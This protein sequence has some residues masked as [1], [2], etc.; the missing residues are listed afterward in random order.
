MRSG[1][2]IRLLC[3]LTVAFVLGAGG[4]AFGQDTDA[5]FRDGM[6]A[7]E[8]AVRLP[9][10]GDR[11]A[12]LSEAVAAFHGIL[13]ERPALGRVRLELARAFFLMG[14][15]ELAR[16]HF[17]IVLAGAIPDLV[18]ANV[19]RFLAT[20]R[21]R[22]R[23]H[24]RFGLGIAPD[25]NI[26]ASSG[27]RSVMID[28]PVGPLPFTLNDPAVKESGVGL[29]VRTGG[30]YQHP[31]GPRWR[32]RAGGNLSRREYRGRNFDHMT[33][34]GHA[35]LRW[36]IDMRTEA[37]LLLDARRR[38]SGGTW[39]NREVGPRL[40]MRRRL[41]RH[42]TAHGG[43][44]WHE[45]RHD[46]ATH[47]DGPVTGLYGG[48][49]W[50]AAPTVRLDL[51]GGLGRE[52]TK[53]R[54]DRNDSRWASAGASWALG[55]GFTVSGALT[56]RRTDYEGGR[57]PFLPVAAKRADETITWRLSAHNRGLTFWGFS[58]RVSLVRE[59]R[60]S[61]AQLHG[62]ERTSG[63]LEFIRLF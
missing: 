54:R 37:S 48:V 30:E 49:S 58:P 39:Q 47:L 29:S 6:A 33:L 59:N 38:Q 28:T 36:L 8:Q 3:V 56:G 27:G 13:V 53:D 62:Y 25:S 50:I 14:E 24:V 43:L 61:N 20:I 17:E 42:V 11:E 32:L 57:W 5:R 16:R 45:R 55:R 15:D 7:V 1:T 23:W 40:E 60:E 26:G 18:A 12:K 63:A 22:K 41:T 21:A 4:S 9:E 35:G 51:S 34:A 52:R 46:R 10:G 31:L 19:R 44:A 2:V